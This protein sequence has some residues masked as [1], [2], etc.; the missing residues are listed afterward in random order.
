M[1]LETISISLDDMPS[2]PSAFRILILASLLEKSS[3]RIMI[4]EIVG[5]TLGINNKLSASN[6]EG[7]NLEASFWSTDAKKNSR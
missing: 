3:C 5:V 2:C 7:G 1:S 4:L 6:A